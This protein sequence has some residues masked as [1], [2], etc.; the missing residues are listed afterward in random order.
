MSDCRNE[1]T[2]TLAVFNFYLSFTIHSS[3]MPPSRIVE[4]ATRIANNTATI[5]DY[6]RSHNLP[7]PSFDVDGPLDTLIPKHETDVES[8]RVAVIDDTL[9][10]RRL[11]LGPRE[12]LMSYTVGAL[13]RQ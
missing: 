7:T 10:L 12:Y 9:E 13:S 11:V 2:D 6:L 8:A 4:L 1:K 5:N 3:T